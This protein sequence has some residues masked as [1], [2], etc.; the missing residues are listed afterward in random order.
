MSQ[1]SVSYIQEWGT[2]EC[3]TMVCVN[4]THDMILKDMAKRGA[5]KAL[6][7]GFNK[8]TKE[9][10]DCRAFI[11]HHSGRTLLWLSKWD[12]QEMLG[13]LLHEI[14]H[15]IFFVME[16]N[17]GME[18]EYEAQAYQGQ[19][20]FNQIRAELNKFYYPKRKTTKETK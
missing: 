20:L 13:V 18:E 15:M 12:N 7:T 16:K 3:D 8:L 1:R 10:Y 19:Y 17:K 6:I 4:M 14:F 9:D 2:Y 11:W 5:K